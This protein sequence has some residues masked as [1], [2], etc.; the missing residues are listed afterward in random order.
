MPQMRNNNK[1]LLFP[2]LAVILIFLTGASIK[3]PFAYPRNSTV[4]TAPLS[5]SPKR[6]ALVIGNSNYLDAPLKNPNN[7][8]ND[9]ATLLENKGFEVTLLL[10]AGLQQMERAILVFSQAL[11]KNGVGLFYFAGHGMEVQNINYLIPVDAR[12]DRASELR[13]EAVNLGRILDGMSEAGNGLNLLI[14]D[15]CRNNPFALEHRGR[16][17]GLARIGGVRGTL[18]MYA[19]EPGQVAE[20]GKGH[21][22]TFT[23]HLMGQIDR[24]GLSVEQV[25]KST[26]IKV[27]KETH[28]RQVPWVSGVILGEFCFQP[29]G[30]PTQDTVTTHLAANQVHIAETALYNAVKDS[31][32]L[33]EME[34]YLRKYPQGIFVERIQRQIAELH[35][36]PTPAPPL[37]KN[38]AW[39]WIGCY[40]DDSDRDLPFNSY[41]DPKMTVQQCTEHCESKGLKVAGVQY[42]SYCFCGK[43]Y[44]KHGQRPDSECGSPCVGD[45][46]ETCGGG[47]RNS[48]WALKNQELEHWGSVEGR[49]NYK[50]VF[51]Y[52]QE[53]KDGPFTNVARALLTEL[54]FER[55]TENHHWQ[56]TGCFEDQGDRDLPFNLISREDMTVNRC[57]FHCYKNGFSIAGVQA[58]SYCLC[59]KDYGKHGQRPDSECATPCPGDNT[60]SCG[61]SWRNA[62]WVL[63]KG[64][65]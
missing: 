5:P 41:S 43:D 36:P 31:N 10:D 32:D 49:R 58:S 35:T 26:A 14:L 56:Y 19:A 9:M 47:W 11:D 42:G 4:E 13:Y 54:E 62:V 6:I 2:F 48:V 34:V 25:F 55:Y 44:G 22:G 38:R 29:S 60:E 17:R 51:K 37:N 57:I 20:E 53:N 46:K 61:G 30:C 59:G 64:N 3:G 28:S 33:E 16:T 8:A 24:P 12:I 63:G 18:V 1:L 45:L 50:E 7:D 15:A 65:K 27:E 21:N 52:T 40:A 39:E 23:K